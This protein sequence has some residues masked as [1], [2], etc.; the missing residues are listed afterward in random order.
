MKV[1]YITTR[2]P[3]PSETFA[4]TDVRTLKALGVDIS[5]Y[6][7]R[8]P[9]KDSGKMIADRGLS[10]I[11]IVTGGV[12][13]NILGL[14]FL[15]VR[16]ILTLRVISWLLKNDFNKP[17]HLLKC[18]L[19]LPSCFY[20]LDKLRKNP[21]DI[22][23]LF[24]GHYPSVVG[25]LVSRSLP[26]VKLT[27]FLGAY[28]LGYSLGI[29]RSIASVADCIFTHAK[30]NLTQFQRLG[31]DPERV[32]VIHRGISIRTLENFISSSGQMKQGAWISAGR[33]IDLK[34]FDHVIELFAK[35]YK[36]GYAK[37]LFIAGDGPNLDR[38]KDLSCRLG[39]SDAVFFNGHMS[40]GDLVRKM[41]ESEYLFLFSKSERLPNVIK[42]GMLSGCICVSSQTTG[43]EE[44]I[45]DGETGFIVDR[46]DCSNFLTVISEMSPAR[47]KLIRQSARNHIKQCFDV[48][49]SMK[50][51]IQKWE[52]L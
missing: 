7:P 48:V 29:S 40:Q 43:I 18:I 25:F 32:S 16:P 34:G 36:S 39:V 5:V 10:E 17:L 28:D 37:S 4:S 49:S 11:P 12:L 6:A 31:I 22:V 8:F 33:L 38:L 30:A 50:S 9:H 14:I 1:S 23:H 41:A 2:F 47:K 35:A 45:E 3:V 20:I 52:S 19:L 24:W 44:L 21:P 13:E 15:I 51:Y 42:E 46:D 27:M 26:Q